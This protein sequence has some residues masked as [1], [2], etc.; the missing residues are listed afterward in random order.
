MQG[1]SLLQRGG[2]NRGF[3]IIT[4][5][6]LDLGGSGWGGGGGPDPTFPFLPE[7]VIR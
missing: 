4:F 3:T 5:N 1:G 6:Q 7:P 2:L